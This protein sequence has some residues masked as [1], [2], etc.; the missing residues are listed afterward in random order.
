VPDLERAGQRPA[1][2]PE[3]RRTGRGQLGQRAGGR[4]RQRAV[5]LAGQRRP[6]QTGQVD[7]RVEVRLGL[8]EQPGAA[9][10]RG[11]APAQ[12]PGVQLG[13]AGGAVQGADGVQVHRGQ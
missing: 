13:A 12:Q 7:Q 3:Q 1:A 11:R 4:D 2:G 10:E 5:G 8:G 9:G 6:A